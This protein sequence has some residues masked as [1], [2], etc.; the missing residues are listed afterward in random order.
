[1]VKKRINISMET[2]K[3]NTDTL[4]VKKKGIWIHPDRWDA[5]YWECSY[6]GSK[7]PKPFDFQYCPHCGAEMEEF[8]FG[9]F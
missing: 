2:T 8:S 5:N 9:L 3:T 1:M 6:C 4:M 7:E